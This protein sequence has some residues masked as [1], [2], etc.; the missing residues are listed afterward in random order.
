MKYVAFT[1]NPNVATT[2]SWFA[3][4][5]IVIGV[6][7]VIA[8]FGYYIIRGHIR[9]IAKQRA[10]VSMDHSN[11]IEPYL[12][13][14]D[15]IGN[16]V[17]NLCWFLLVILVVVAAT[18]LFAVLQTDTENDHRLAEHQAT[19]IKR[20]YGITFN[21]DEVREFKNSNTSD[22]YAY[23]IYVDGDD[24]VRTASVT[25]LGRVDDEWEQIEYRLLYIGDNEVRLQQ[26]ST[27]LTG[28]YADDEGFVDTPLVNDTGE[29]AD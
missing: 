5:I 29:T 6:V 18:W 22:R 9:H 14:W 2:P 20:T 13:K 27:A 11:E 21:A 12:N 17:E 4:V 7:L 15:S 28:P 19:I 16:R 8:W 26:H 3:P 24:V 10:H 25:K 1:T 23:P